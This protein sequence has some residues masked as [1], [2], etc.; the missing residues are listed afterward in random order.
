MKR[1][2]S[3]VSA[4]LLAHRRLAPR[5]LRLAA[6][7]RLALATAVGMVARVHHRSA[8]RRPDAEPAAAAGLAE[9]IVACSGLPT[10]PI[11]AMQVMCTR[12]TSPRRQADLWPSR[13]PSPSTAP[14]RRRCAPSGR[15]G[16]AAARCCGSRYPSGCRA[17][18]A[19]C[20]A[21]S[22]ASGPELTSA[23]YLQADRRDDV[24]LL[25]VL[26]LEQ[27]DPRRAVRVVLDRRRP[28]PAR[29]ACSRFQSMMRY[30]R[31]WPPPRWRTVMR[32]LLLR[33]PDFF[34]GSSSDRSGFLPFV[35]SSNVETDMPRRPGEVGWYSFSG[36]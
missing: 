15:H 7:R 1:S 18:P 2:V 20:P 33:P 36:T 28:G 30:I 13:L 34:S 22:S 9:V 23:A 8:H 35:I 26:V 19:R 4:G 12:R 14:R 5:R 3:L 31:L 32:P 16:R 10:W 29:R 17:G 6:D 24:A 11:V 25:A 27:R 21:R